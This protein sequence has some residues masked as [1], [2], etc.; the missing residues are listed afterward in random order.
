VTLS[1]WL[2]SL[3]FT[4]GYFHLFSPA[5]IF[6]NLLAVPIAFAVLALGVAALVAASF[7]VWLAG[8]FN[9]AN[10][11]AAKALVAVVEIFAAVPGGYIYVELP[12]MSRAPAC[13]LTVLD[14]GGGG[15]VFVRS[16]ERNWLL[17]TGSTAAYDRVVLPYL[18]TRGVNRLDGLLLTHGDSHHVGGA[19]DALHDFAPQ[20]IVDSALRDRSPTRSSFHSALAVRRLGKAISQRGDWLRVSPSASMRVLFPPAG[21]QRATADDKALVVQLESAGTRVLLMSDSGFRTEQWLL[22]NE[23]DLRSD[24]VIKSQHAADFSGTLEFLSRVAPQAVI[25]GRHGRDEPAQNLDEWEASV[26]AKGI[27]VFRQDRSGAVR[28]E[29]REGGAFELSA[30][31]GG[32]TFRSRAR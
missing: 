3:A 1:A 24:I 25:C 29:L 15:A 22:E 12:R 6:A 18:R 16:Q 11:L 27:V 5:A 8:I 21:I 23:P 9:N 31:V 30:F 4:A 20:Q 32:Q 10:W 26:A 17:D 13:E 7:S 14:V 2:G 28:V 19:I